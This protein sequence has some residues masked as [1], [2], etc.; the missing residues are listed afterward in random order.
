MMY[1]FVRKSHFFLI[2]GVELSQTAPSSVLL[3]A[4]EIIQNPPCILMMGVKIC[5]KA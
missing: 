5:H 2:V 4:V 1:D 3:M